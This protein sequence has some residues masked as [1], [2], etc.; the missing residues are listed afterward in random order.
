VH[1][2]DLK[3][4]LATIREIRNAS[5]DTQFEKDDLVRLRAPAEEELDVNDPYFRLSLDMYIILTNASQETYRQLVAAF[6]RCHPE[7]TGRLLSYDQIKR[8]VKNL[9]GIIPIH[10]DMCVNSCMAFTGP[11]KD[12]NTCLKC[13][14]PRYDPV[15]LHSSND[16][17]KKPWQSMTTI[18]IGPQIQALWS[19]R[20]SAEKMSYREQVTNTLLGQDESPNI[21]TNYTKGVDYRMNVRGPY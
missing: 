12:L 14:E 3:A 7:A 13:P 17:I 8:R 18:P 10:D 19:H 9:T 21:L 4:T 6:L 11:H 15:L 1:L 20:L 16:T 2:D 5:L